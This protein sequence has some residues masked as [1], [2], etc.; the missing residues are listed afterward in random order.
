MRNINHFR[1]LICLVILLSLFIRP[2]SVY[3]CSCVIP[4][5]PAEEFFQ[6]DAVFSGTV[7]KIANNYIPF[8]TEFMRYNGFFESFLTPDYT[9]V[10]GRF[11]GNSIFFSVTNSWKGVHENYVEIDSGYGMGDCGY[12]FI[13]NKEYLVYANS[14]YGI[15]DKYLVTGTCGRTKELGNAGEELAYLETRPVLNLE[16]I[17]PTFWTE[18]NYIG[19]A[20]LYILVTIS[21]II[22][23][24]LYRKQKLI[25]KS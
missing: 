8:V 2:T 13:E 7:V 22:V 12:S 1:L 15:P 5:T 9:N 4:G 6:H 11:Y 14:A 21:L 23:F 17:S 3:A 19:F 10:D 16:I 20:L 24:R 25:T 18:K